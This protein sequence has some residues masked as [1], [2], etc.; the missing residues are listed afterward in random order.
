[1][2]N[3]FEKF[4]EHFV[5]YEDCYTIIGGTA[6]D[7]L[8]NDA[9]ADFRLTKDIDMILLIENR[10]EEFAEVFWEFIKAGNYKC[11][12]RNSETP[13]FYRF[14]EPLPGYPV[15]IEL[16]SKRPDFQLN[17]TD[18]HL[19]PLPVSEEISSLSAIMLDDNYY[20]LMLKGKKVIG[21]ISVLDTEYLIV[22]KIKAYLDLRQ[23]KANGEHVNDRDLKKHKNDVFRLLSIVDGALQIMLPSAVYN[24]VHEFISIVKAE[25]VNLKNL[26]LDDFAPETYYRILSSI[27]IS[28]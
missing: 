21:G 13:H 25:P 27:Y 17:H 16:F 10:F 18:I 28:E 2:V 14:T 22:F 6:C 3:G 12:W 7:I 8:M 9:S 26:R 5:G 23:K 20:H 4:K 11:G 15:M 1:M 24:E 19:T